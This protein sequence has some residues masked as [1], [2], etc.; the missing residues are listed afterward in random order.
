VG[1]ENKAGS[2]AVMFGLGI[3]ENGMVGKFFIYFAFLLFFQLL[4]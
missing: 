3:S 4:F 1:G 2:V